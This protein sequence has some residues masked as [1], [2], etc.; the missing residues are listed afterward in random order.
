RPAAPRRPAGGQHHGH[1]A[2]PGPG[3]RRAGGALLRAAAGRIVADRTPAG[4]GEDHGAERAW[5]SR[6]ATDPAR[7]GGTDPGGTSH[8]PALAG[9]FV[10]CSNT[11]PT[12]IWPPDPVLLRAAGVAAVAL[13]DG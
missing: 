11:V 6:S 12:E 5:L 10:G 7:R 8:E 3:L 9:A 13:P 4:Q 1:P 2:G